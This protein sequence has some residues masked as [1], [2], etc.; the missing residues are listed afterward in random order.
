MTR[1]PNR[2]FPFPAALESASCALGDAV[3]PPSAFLLYVQEFKKK[4][5]KKKA[6]NEKKAQGA[7]PHGALQIQAR[8]SFREEKTSKICSSS[9][10]G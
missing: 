10:Q 1:Q 6:Q 5:K 9:S 3:L 2:S 4:K 8:A 7:W